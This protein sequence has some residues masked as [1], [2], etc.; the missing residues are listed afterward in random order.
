MKQIYLAAFSLLL[1]TI[2]IAGPKIT[3]IQNNGIWKNNSTWDLNRKPMNGDT[4]I[5]PAGYNV[6]LDNSQTLNNL[7]IKIYGKL[8]LDKGK[9][10][11]NALSKI[12]VYAPGKIWGHGQGNGESISIG[13]VNKFDDNISNS[14]VPG[15][16]FADITTGISPNGFSPFSSLPVK[17][18]GFNVALQNNNVLVQWA[19][20]EEMNSSYYEIQRSENGTSWITIANIAAAGTT[21]LTHSYSFTDIN[22]T[23]KLVYYRIRQVDIDGKFS[24]T[25]V[26]MIKSA[27][28]NAEIKITAASSGSVYVHFSEQVRTNVMIRFTS[29]NGQT[30][31]ETTVNEPVGQVLVPAKKS[32]KGIYIVTV[33]NGQDLKVSKQILF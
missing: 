28:G 30:V 12:Y 23:A 31:S 5:I 10:I 2:S 9:L 21:S 18:I 27:S 3:A 1:A 6:I 15:T 20:A 7:V 4:V 26:R 32:I 17:F 16:Q 11:L 8:E 24:L 13:G 19:T 29:L 22:V 14:Q 33:T 25:P